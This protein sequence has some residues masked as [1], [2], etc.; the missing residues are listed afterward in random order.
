MFDSVQMEINVV[1]YQDPYPTGEPLGVEF[2]SDG[3]KKVFFEDVSLL[4]PKDPMY[5]LSYATWIVDGDARDW[6]E[7]PITMTGK[8]FG[9]CQF[10]ESWNYKIDKRRS[11]R[12]DKVLRLVRIDTG[13]VI[14]PQQ[15]CTFIGGRMVYPLFSK[16]F[17]VDRSCG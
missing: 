8:M 5:I 17:G 9:E 11:Y 10:F 15:L 12:F 1:S 4:V 6:Y 2:F 7:I 14:T 16:E 3:S 13:E